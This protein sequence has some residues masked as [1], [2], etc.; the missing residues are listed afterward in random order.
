MRT[1][2]T[3]PRARY[4]GSMTRLKAELLLVFAAAIWGLAFVFQKSAL[5]HVEP[6]TFIMARSI[7]AALALAPLAYVEGG[8]TGRP[9]SRSLAASSGAG[10][11]LFFLG[12]A[13]Q[14]Q[15]LITA[16][17]TSTGFLTALYVVFTPLIAW[18]AMRRRP[19]VLVW[20]A[21]ALS[22][23]GTWLL[24]GGSFGGFSRGDALVAICALFWAA[25]VV[26]TSQSSAHGRPILFTALQFAG[27]AAIAMAGA[28]VFETPRLAGIVAAR[29][30]IAY[31]GLLSSALTFTLLAVALRHTPPA[32]AAVIVS[33]EMLFA[34]LAAYLLLGERVDP[35]GWIGAGL[36]LAAVLL[37][38]L[39]PSLWRAVGASDAA[40]RRGA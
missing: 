17:V 30:E 24:G 40:G 10:A 16:S 37:V 11:V 21:V 9:A 20:P 33:A 35:L 19:T 27:V 22:F 38:Q 2:A 26:V 28:F 4:A 32:E 13:F 15:G 6:M 36:I 23:A 7:R 1:L 5:D 34:A 25:H 29:V 14:Q 12:A 8:R 39:G 31:V 18:A 3:R